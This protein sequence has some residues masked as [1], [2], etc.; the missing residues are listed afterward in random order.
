MNSIESNKQVAGSHT[1]GPWSVG[2]SA[3]NGLPCVDG[4]DP[5][6][7]SL[8]EIC[9]VWVEEYDLEITE[10]SN[11]NARRIVAC[12]NACDGISTEYLETTGLPEFAGKTLCADIAQDE[13]DKVERQR[14]EL[15]TKVADLDLALFAEN[16]KRIDVERQRDQLLAALDG[17]LAEHAVPSS[18]CK[19]RQAYEQALSAIAA[20]KGGTPC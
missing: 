20:V 13:L 19:D 7:G 5:K 6:D 10:M 17:L 3:E 2:V 9:E 12:V 4:I 11:A 18:G 15:A 14:D 16:Q 8:F 1:P